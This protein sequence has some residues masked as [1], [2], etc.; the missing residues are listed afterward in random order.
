MRIEAIALLQLRDLRPPADSGARVTSLDDSL[1]LH[2]GA[3]FESDPETLANVVRVL[4]GEQLTQ[5]EDPRGIFFI[6]SVAAPS[7]RTYR[8]VIE[9]IGEGGMWAPRPRRGSMGG[10]DDSFEALLGSMLGQIPSGLL[11]QVTRAA[12]QGDAGTLERMTSDLQAL[13]GKNPDLVALTQQT[14]PVA[15]QPRSPPT[16]RRAQTSYS[17]ASASTRAIPASRSCSAAP[18]ASTSPHPRSATSSPRS[19]PS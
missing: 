6:P 15:A 3:T 8:A 19:R 12:T 7:A 18:R 5:H 16:S 2:T 11:E 4:A 1:L 13:L 9:E 17:Q 14:A 10:P